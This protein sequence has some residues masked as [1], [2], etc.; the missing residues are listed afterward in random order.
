MSADRGKAVANC[1]GVA[2]ASC[3]LLARSAVIASPFFIIGTVNGDIEWGPALLG[4]LY[5]TASSLALLLPLVLLCFFPPF[6]RARL[7]GFL[8]VPQP[9]P[10]AGAAVPLGM[11]EAY[12]FK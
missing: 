12:Q 8:K 7:C 2:C 10:S 5:V 1:T 4:M 9:G 11:A 3:I 6:Y